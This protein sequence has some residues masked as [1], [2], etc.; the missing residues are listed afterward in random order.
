MSDARV[1]SG[2]SIPAPDDRDV[3]DPERRYES[4]QVFQSL[5]EIQKDI[6]SI[7]TKTDRLI[8][9]FRTL[10]AKVS[11]LDT[12]LTLAKGFGIAAIILIPICATIVWWLVG[13]KLEN[14]R[15]QLLGASRPAATQQAAPSP[16]ALI[17]PR[18]R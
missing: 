7:S 2:P 9:D 10:D 17:Q 11:G 3:P 5:I 8:T 14:L 16:P 6:S 12:S 18:N 4:M 1:P 13:S 15:D